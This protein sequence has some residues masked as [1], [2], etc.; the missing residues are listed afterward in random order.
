[1]AGDG[2]AAAAQGRRAAD[3]GQDFRRRQF[4]AVARVQGAAAVRVDGGVDVPA[5]D[6]EV[7][8]AGGEGDALLVAAAVLFGLDVLGG[9]LRAFETGLGDEVDHA[10]DGVR[11]VD[12]GGAV[13]QDLDAGDR[14]HRDHVEVGVAVGDRFVG[15]APAVE[16][17]QGAV[18][19]QAAQVDV[20]A[21]AGVRRRQRG[22]LRQRHHQVGQGGHAACRE[23]LGADGGDGQRR[24]GG[25]AL[26]AGTGDFDALHRAFLGRGA[27]VSART[28][29]EI[30][31]KGEVAG[32]LA[33]LVHEAVS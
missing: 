8:A 11:T 23:F 3:A 19:A 12:R 21:R 25:E 5:V 7:A 1:L 29:R 27:L 6:G 28:A 4:G 30:E 13:A 22:R 16:Q 33:C 32:G 20:G 26:D 15:Q 24:F 9:D 17:H 10:A 31:D 2:I 18:H 14:A